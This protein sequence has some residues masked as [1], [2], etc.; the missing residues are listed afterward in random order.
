MFGF[1]AD[2]PQ[3]EQEVIFVLKYKWEPHLLFW[4]IPS[5]RD[6]LRQELK[7]GKHVGSFIGSF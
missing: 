6:I 2:P 5:G 7:D 3:S 1:H 4:G